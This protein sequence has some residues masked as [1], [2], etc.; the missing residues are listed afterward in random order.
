MS[1]KPTLLIVVEG[2][3]VQDVVC[4]QRDVFERILLVDY[5]TDGAE[6]KDLFEV[7]QADGSTVEA[8]VRDIAPCR[9]AIDL[10][11][12]DALDDAT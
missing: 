7:E 1:K 11:Q 8:L 3:V 4:D 2:G 10:S 9:P 5:D 6:S 12:F